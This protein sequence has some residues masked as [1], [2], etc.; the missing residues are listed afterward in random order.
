MKITRDVAIDLWPMVEAGEASAD[1]QAIVE[2]FTRE[3]PEFARI[4]E[5]GRRLVSLKGAKIPQLPSDHEKRTLE[6]TRRRLRRRSWFLAA[7]ILFLG[8]S[9]TLVASSREGIIWF[10]WR[11]Q[12]LFAACCLVTSILF[13]F[14]Y[15]RSGERIRTAAR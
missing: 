8:A 5:R 10:T 4:V 11:D 7:A 14:L 9:S 12:P 13:W 6:A 2:A 3:D 1:S 15:A